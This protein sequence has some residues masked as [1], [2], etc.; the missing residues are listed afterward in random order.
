MAQERIKRYTRNKIHHWS[1]ALSTPNGRGTHTKAHPESSDRYQVLSSFLI[2]SEVQECL[3]MLWAQKVKGPQEEKR[4]QQG[5]LGHKEV[6]SLLF[7]S[8]QLLFFRKL[9]FVLSPLPVAPF[10][11]SFF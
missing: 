10:L 9:A 11:Y 5:I 1:K 8:V 7:T 6:K 2:A 3:K 4:I